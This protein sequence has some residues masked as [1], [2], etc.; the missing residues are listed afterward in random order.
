MRFLPL[1]WMFKLGFLGVTWLVLT[2]DFQL[3]LPDTVL[4]YAV[5]QQA[6]EWVERAQTDD[7]TSGFDNIA[8]HLK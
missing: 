4:G 6:K 1:R 5:P 3:K 7:V 2:G 8:G